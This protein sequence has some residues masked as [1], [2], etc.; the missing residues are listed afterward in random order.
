MT[1]PSIPVTYSTSKIRPSF[2]TANGFAMSIACLPYHTSNLLE[3]NDAHRH[4]RIR[5][6]LQNE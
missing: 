1:E 3:N 4:A 6:W 2:Y 5:G